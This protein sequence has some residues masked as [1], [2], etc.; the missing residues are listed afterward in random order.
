MTLRT[1]LIAWLFL[2]STLS[3]NPLCKTDF[4]KKWFLVIEESGGDTPRYRHGIGNPD[5]FRTSWQPL[6]G[7]KFC[8]D[9][10]ISCI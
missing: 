8:R 4:G 3:A 6:E 1:H 7:R 10:P 5:H 9:N 2:L